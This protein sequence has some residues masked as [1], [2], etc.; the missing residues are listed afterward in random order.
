MMGVLQ[1]ELRSQL[2]IMGEDVARSMRIVNRLFYESTEN[3]SYATLFVGIYDDAHRKLSYVNCGHNPP[4]HLH[5]DKVERLSA[6]ATVLGLFEK[7]ECE[8]REIALVPGD[9]LTL[10]TDGVIEAV[11]ENQQEFGTDRLIKVLSESKRSG[12]ST[13]IKDVLSKVKDFAAGEQGD[14]ITVL[15]AVAR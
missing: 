12:P 7:W 9:V 10:Y 1:G 5:G 8:V 3:C 11:D 4:L 14:D 13:L 2:A 6:T 15:V